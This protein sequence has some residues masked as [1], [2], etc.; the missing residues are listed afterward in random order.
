MHY[1][2]AGRLE[3][4][5]RYPQPLETEEVETGSLQIPSEEVAGNTLSSMCRHTH[6]APKLC[7]CEVTL[8]EIVASSRAVEVQPCSS[9]N[10]PQEQ[11]S[12]YP[13]E[14]PSVEAQPCSS[15]NVPE[16]EDSSS[17][18]TR[19][20]TGSLPFMS[21]TKMTFAEEMNSKKA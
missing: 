1:S 13:Q 15:T 3:D 4:E 12:R 6:L 20:Q 19:S 7:T 10:V 14:E 18:Q 2:S 17:R 5:S 11:Q 9:T 21:P 16:G 8:S